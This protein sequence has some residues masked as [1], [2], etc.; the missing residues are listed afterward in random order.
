MNNVDFK[1]LDEQLVFDMYIYQLVKAEIIASFK[2]TLT[3][4][5]KTVLVF[6]YTQ[7]TFIIIAVY[8]AITLLTAKKITLQNLFGVILQIPQK[9]FTESKLVMKIVTETLI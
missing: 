1:R 6:N 5:T 2:R 9:I 7:M 4:F 8:A 3:T